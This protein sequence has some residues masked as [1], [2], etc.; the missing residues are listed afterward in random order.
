VEGKQGEHT[1]PIGRAGR[2]AG[3]KVRFK[4][5]AGRKSGS[6]SLARALQGK[7]LRAGTYW[8][9]VSSLDAE[10]TPSA[11][12]RVKVWILKARRG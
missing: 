3:G 1:E 2:K 9:Q 6:V 11:S 12:R 5:H 8:L 10:G 4:L 7:R